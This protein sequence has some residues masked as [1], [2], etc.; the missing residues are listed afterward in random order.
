MK[1]KTLV[2]S[3]GLIAIAWGAFIFSN[4]YNK[5]AKIASTQDI[6]Q[7]VQDYSTRM[8]VADSASITSHKLTVSDE[9]EG[10]STYD[11]PQDEFFVS[12]AP[13]VESTH[14]CEIHSLTGCQGEMADQE[15]EVNIVDDEGNTVLNQKMKTYGNGFVDLWLPRDKTYKVKISHDGKTANSEI[16]TFEGD[17]TCIT[18][19]Q[20]V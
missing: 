7:L 9:G 15:F 20:L 6:K 17:N 13:F 12:I 18:T 5:E 19:M 16:S 4:G 11:L 8:K 2:I 14:P 3:I 1:R 10:T